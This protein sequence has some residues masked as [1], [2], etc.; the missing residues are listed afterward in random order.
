M[1]FSVTSATLYLNTFTYDS[2]NASQIYTLFDISTDLGNLLSGSAG[3][4]AYNDFG[5]G[6]S[7]GGRVYTAADDS[8]FGPLI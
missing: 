7:Y 2:F 6:V 3:V 5:S 1:G 8:A 4:G